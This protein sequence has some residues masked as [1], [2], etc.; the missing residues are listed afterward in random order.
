M[1]P[2][3]QTATGLSVTRT[4][5]GMTTP[6]VL[7]STVAGG[8]LMLDSRMLEPRRPAREPTEA[9]KAEGLAQYSPVLPLRHTWFLTAN[10]SVPRVRQVYSTPT[11]YESTTLVAALGLDQFYA[12]RAPAREF[13]QLDPDYNVG[14]FLVVIAASAAGAA[15]LRRIVQSREHAAA[16][17]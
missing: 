12:R 3:L 13:D 11:E 15:V 7:M 8:V 6:Q 2:F 10:A 17:K 14:F 1:R 16:W 5:Q 9:E 4:R